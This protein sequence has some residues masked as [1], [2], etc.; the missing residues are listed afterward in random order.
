[1]NI[2]LFVFSSSCSIWIIKNSCNFDEYILFLG[3]LIFVFVGLGL[4]T[5]VKSGVD[6][7]V[8]SGIGVLSGF[9]VAD[10][11]LLKLLRFFSP[12]SRR[13]HKFRKDS[14][15]ICFQLWIFYFVLHLLLIKLLCCIFPK[16]LTGNEILLKS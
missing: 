4:S 2:S 5:T 16:E 3:S 8:G 9:F 7:G 1:M 10:I 6:S 14:F 12:A 15:L 11:L 13:K